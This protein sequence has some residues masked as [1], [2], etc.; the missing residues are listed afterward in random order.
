MYVCV[1]SLNAKITGLRVQYPSL[2][3]LFCK[4]NVLPAGTSPATGAE[5]ELK[6][7]KTCCRE[8]REPVCLFRPF[9][10]VR[11]FLPSG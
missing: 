9:E 7:I 3:V 8:D 2:D 11:I 10:F 1:P 5:T 6:P 4:Q